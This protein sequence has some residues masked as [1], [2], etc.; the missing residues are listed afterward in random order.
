MEDLFFLVWCEGG[1]A[2]TFKHYTFASAK[3]E[4]A[5]LAR[6][7]PDRRFTVMVAVQGV[8]VSDLKTTRYLGTEQSLAER[9]L[10]EEV[11]F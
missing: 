2:P 9:E 6:L 11:P 7:S 8:E 4:A 3:A 5:R 10:D 1:G